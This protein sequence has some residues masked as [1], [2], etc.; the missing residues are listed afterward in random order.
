MRRYTDH[1]CAACW[2]SDCDCDCATCVAA[3]AMTPEQRRDTF[4]QEAAEMLMKI[5]ATR[6]DA[7]WTGQTN[8]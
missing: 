3:R 5:R 1:D 7:L 8:G 2:Q 4:R 6:A